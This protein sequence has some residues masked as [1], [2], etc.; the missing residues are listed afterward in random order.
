M[1]RV[2]LS[3]AFQC[4][5]N[6]FQGKFR[7]ALFVWT[8]NASSSIGLDEYPHKDMAYVAPFYH[9]AFYPS[10]VVTCASQAPI[11]WLF[12]RDLKSTKLSMGI[13]VA[14]SVQE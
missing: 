6:A 9:F 4:V 13:L 14:A 8:D 11:F 1:S 12:C 7:Q 2:H 10:A 5:E 3:L